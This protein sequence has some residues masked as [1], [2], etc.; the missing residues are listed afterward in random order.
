[1][2]VSN[3]LKRGLKTK[4]HVI[5][6]LITISGL[7]MRLYMAHVDPFLHPWDERFHA[8]VA[9]NMMNDP[10]KPM[11]RANPV[12]NNYDPH[13]W[14]CNHIWVHKQPL[15]MWQMAASMKLFG[16][17][18]FTM[19]LPSV[20][21]GTIMI[22]LLYRLVVLYTH[23]S[24]IALIASGLLAFSNF[25]MLM[26]GGIQG[27]D[28]NDVALGFYVLA[29]IWAYAEYVKNPKWYW[30][31]LIGLF[32]GCAVLNKWLLGLLVFA[33]WGINILIH[34]RGDR[35]FKKIT[36][37]VLAMLVCCVVFVPWQLY[38]LH[39]F[40]N[41][42]K[43]EFEFNRRHITEALEGHTGTI[44]FYLKNMP[45]LFG[46]GV[47]LFLLIGVALA[48]F[49]K[50]YDKTLKIALLSEII[51]VFLF[52]SLI[53][54]TKVNTYFFFVAPLCLVFSA[55]AIYQFCLLI[56]K[57]YFI[58]PV[59]CGVCFFVLDP[60]QIRNYLSSDNVERNNRIYNANIYRNLKKLLPP[61]T[62]LIMNMNSFEDIDV[63]FYNNDI[64]ANHWLLPDEDINLIKQKKLRIAVFEPHGTY[65]IPQSIYS[66]PWLFI[67]PKKLKD[68]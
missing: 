53:V 37:F 50:K 65:N 34:L 32:A 23:N 56:K 58:I 43:F 35:V 4:E 63:M 7:A 9:R 48:F 28:H 62:K 54:A 44:F 39:A 29:S 38:I 30:I 3:V 12:T 36:H 1:M 14:C 19:R 18:E 49:G 33:G 68:F 40:P 24:R 27:M 2:I 26:I 42:A 67:I 55:A 21:M 46:Q 6:L 16:V 66:Y 51:I 5:L 45:V 22:V 13:I 64:T 11:L 57:T 60:V 59:L 41:E 8:L 61:D 25:H 17:S 20:F 15:F 47:F 10:F 31:P 52:F